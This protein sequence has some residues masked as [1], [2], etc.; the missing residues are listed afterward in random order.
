MRRDLGAR[1]TDT[2]IL[3]G[4]AFVAVVL[5]MAGVSV[6]IAAGLGVVVGMLWLLGEVW[7]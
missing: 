5:A 2:F 7:R 1:I 3:A 4:Q 6:L